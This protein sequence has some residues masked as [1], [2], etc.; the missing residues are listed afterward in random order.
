MK[1]PATTD[2]QIPQSEAP[3][4][5]IPAAPSPASQPVDQPEALVTTKSSLGSGVCDGEVHKISAVE[6][7]VVYVA[8]YCRVSTDLEEQ[9]GSLES[10]V[11]HWTEYVT[12]HG[13]AWSL[14]GV[15]SEQ[16]LSAT[17]AETRPVLMELLTHCREGKVNLILTKSISRFSRNTIDCLSLVRAV[18]VLGVAIIFE[19]ENI[20]TGSM[21]SELFLTLLA[22]FAAEESRNISRNVHM[23]Y[24][25]RFQTGTYKYVRPPYGYTVQEGQL[26][27]DKGEAEIVRDIFDMARGLR[28]SQKHSRDAVWL[29]STTPHGWVIL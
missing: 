10:Q 1:Q 18:K 6:R 23:G 15:Y 16:G 9:E 2:Q 11:A 28:L 25:H 8:A 13:P 29:R 4:T 12:T 26:I 22:S 5:I 24:T 27:P 3:V 19:K 14:V 20:D 21:T 17:H 7:P